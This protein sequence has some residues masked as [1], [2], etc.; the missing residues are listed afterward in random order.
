MAQTNG[1]EAWGP[2]RRRRVSTYV[3]FILLSSHSRPWSGHAESSWPLRGFRVPVQLPRCSV[4]S[5]STHPAEAGYL[6]G[7]ATTRG[8]EQERALGLTLCPLSAGFPPRLFV[9]PSSQDTL[10]VL[11]RAIRSCCQQNFSSS[12]VFL[13]TVSIIHGQLWPPNGVTYM[14]CKQTAFVLFSFLKKKGCVSVW[15]CA[16]GYSCP[17]RLELLDSRM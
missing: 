2:G 6:G 11:V 8:L 14:V 17:L 5:S 9:C 15:L 16:H 7:E 1:N 4:L 3:S 10:P 13:S 12:A